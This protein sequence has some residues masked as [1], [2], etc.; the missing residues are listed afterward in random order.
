MVLM[1]FYLVEKEHRPDMVNLFQFTDS[2]ASVIF[3]D[4]HFQLLVWIQMGDEIC[5]FLGVW[6]HDVSF[7]QHFSMVNAVFVV[8]RS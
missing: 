1:L 7:S 3:L 8:S 6:K 5:S 2:G 4:G